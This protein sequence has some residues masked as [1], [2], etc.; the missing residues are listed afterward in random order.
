M[1]SFS[2]VV[3][4]VDSADKVRIDEAQYEISQMLQTKYLRN[5]P[6]VFVANK[7]DAEGKIRQTCCYHCQKVQ[8]MYFFRI[9]FK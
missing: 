4:V 8:C 7:Q 2:A 9:F 5:V 3:F 6:M 1:R